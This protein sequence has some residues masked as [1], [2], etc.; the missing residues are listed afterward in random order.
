[1]AWQFAAIA[2]GALLLLAGIALTARF[3][4]LR[5]LRTAY[6]EA[7]R[8]LENEAINH[9]LVSATPIG[10]CITRRSDYSIPNGNALAAQWLQNEPAPNTLPEHIVAAFRAALPAADEARTAV[11]AVPLQPNQADAASAQFLQFTVAPARYDGK[12]V[13]FCAIVDITTQHALETQLRAAQQATEAAM[14]ERSNFFA[15]MSHEIR[16]PLNALLGNLELFART[17]GLEAYEQRVHLLGVAAN[18][19]R[20]IVNDVLDFSKIDAGEMKLVTESF[21]LIEAFE[22]LALSY[23]SMVRGR[24]IRF[25]SL[26]SHRLVKSCVGTGPASRRSSTTC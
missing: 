6:I 5:M 25:D 24:P 1:M 16:T 4:G 17:P 22:N 15:S 19:L 12:D 7:T 21:R 23:A 10:L 26:L 8:A 9:V 20:R 3:W 11:F 18:A 13:L 14:R 2:G